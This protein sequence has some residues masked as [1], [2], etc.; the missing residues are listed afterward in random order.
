MKAMPTRGIVGRIAAPLTACSVTLAGVWWAWPQQLPAWRSAAIIS[1][2]TASGL[3]VTSL[4]LMVREP[5]LA[6]LLGGLE[7]SYRWHH[8]CGLLAYLILLGHPLALAIDAWGEA[9]QL[10]WQTLNPL[11]QSWPLW[12][13]WAGLLLLMFGLTATLAIHLPYRQWRGLHWVL[14]GGV[15]LGLSHVYV[16]LGHEPLLL[17]LS[18]I[19]GIALAW[20]ALASDLGL[21]AHPYRVTQVETRAVNMIEASL[22]PCAAALSPTPGQFVLAAFGD[23]VHYRGDHEYHPFTVSGMDPEGRLRISV[24]ALGPASRRIQKVEPGVL[25]R[26]Q[27]PF[28]NFLANLGNTPQLWVAGGIGITPFIAGLRAHPCQQATTLIYLYRSLPD[29]MFLEELHGLAAEDPLFELLSEACGNQDPD[30]DRL[31]GQ[32]SRLSEREVQMC[33]PPPM[34]ATLI[35]AL[36]RRGIPSASIHFESF[37][38]R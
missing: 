36:Y 37:D 15:L 6:R 5:H 10:A 29:A 28:G 11:A 27:G 13:G 9:P 31:L 19:A 20:R 7:A 14:A 4:L 25:V 26:L 30:V 8:R 24:K 32:V 38:F 22:A 3:L 2:W 17:G 21:L 12:L 23:G 35:A 33:G 34:L 16:L 1:G 18:A